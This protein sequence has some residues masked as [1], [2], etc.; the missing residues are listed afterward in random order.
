MECFESIQTRQ[1]KFLRKVVHLDFA[2]NLDFDRPNGICFSP[3][4]TVL[5]VADTSNHS[6]R[7]YDVDSEGHISNPRYRKAISR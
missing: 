3:D 7:A 5:Y 2:N 4:Q 1:Y 6:I